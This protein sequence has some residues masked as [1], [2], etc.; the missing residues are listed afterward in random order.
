MEKK[1]RKKMLISIFLISCTML[2]AGCGEKH[3]ESDAASGV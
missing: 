1:I 3:S 2:F